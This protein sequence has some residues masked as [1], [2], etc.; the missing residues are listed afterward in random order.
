[1]GGRGPLLDDVEH[2]PPVQDGEV[3]G[4]PDRVDQAR[5]DGP[6]QPGQ[7]LL[8]G[9]GA[10]DL[11]SADAEAVPAFLR[12]VD[13][14]PGGDQLT[15]QVVGR[16]PGEAEVAGEDR[17]GHRTRLTSQGLQDREGVPGSGDALS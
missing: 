9:V 6:G 16:G 1:M 14:E 3:G 8:P 2:L 10:A 15:E 13:D 12:Q 11:E 17:G 4:V 5:E 7:G